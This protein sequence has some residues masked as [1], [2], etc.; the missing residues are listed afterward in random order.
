LAEKGDA[1]MLQQRPGR[2]VEYYRRALAKDPQLSLD[3]AFMSKLNRA[4]SLAQFSEGSALAGQGRWAAAVPRFAESVEADPTFAKAEEAL[5]HART[6]ASDTA[7]AE[8]IEL[9]QEGK[10][11]R[12]LL[13]LKKAQKL[14]PD[15]ADLRELSHWLTQFNKAQTQAR[16]GQWDQAVA[17]FAESAEAGSKF[18][19][20]VAALQLAK[21][22]ASK[23]HHQKGLAFA[24]EGNLDQ[25][26]VEVR[27][28]LELDPDNRDAQA[29]LESAQSEA[30][31]TRG[32]LHELYRRARQLERER[33]WRKVEGVLE[34][35][36]KENPNDISYRAARW[37]ARKALER[38]GELLL[39]GKRLLADRRLA[40]AQDK[41]SASLAIWP[42]GEEAPPLLNKATEQLQEAERHLPARA[43]SQTRRCGMRPSRPPRRLSKY[44]PITNRPRPS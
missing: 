11:D 30:G 32:S 13:E 35:A 15:N 14:D 4:R 1:L 16:D 17:L 5:E 29:S 40:A 2:A 44:S 8:A 3:S 36:L 33:L 34:Q 18:P 43:S 19:Q 10:L 38:A 20:A 28:A 41:L 39:E 25:A 7:Y 23:M 6:K 9:A 22:E 42:H 26:V 37:R 21:R 27:M 24:D 12:A 31:E